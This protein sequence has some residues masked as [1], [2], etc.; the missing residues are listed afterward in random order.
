MI[1]I[2]LF[3]LATCRQSANPEDIKQL[4]EAARFH[5]EAYAVHEA[6]LKQ[7]DEA[8]TLIRQLSA[9][10]PANIEGS[11]PDQTPEVPTPDLPEQATRLEALVQSVKDWEK[12]Q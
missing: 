1:G 9:S 11:T 8:E 5:Q 6:V 3:G 4:E 7:V 12:M 10:N 2:C